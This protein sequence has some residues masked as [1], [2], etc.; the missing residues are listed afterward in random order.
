LT[1]IR[2]T[3]NDYVR[4]R[5][6]CGRGARFLGVSYAYQSKRVEPQWP[7]S[8][9]RPRD[10]VLGIFLTAANYEFCHSL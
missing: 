7:W 2:L 9:P 8:W 4:Q 3:Q 10:F 1:W 6:T 5:N